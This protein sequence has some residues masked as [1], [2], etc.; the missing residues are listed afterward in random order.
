MDKDIVSG[1]FRDPSGFLFYEEDS[2]YRQINLDYKEDYDILMSSGLYNE[3]VSQMLLI[4][5][6]ESNKNLAKSNEVYK[7]IKPDKIKFISYPYEWSFSQLKD[8]AL[9]TL[10]IIKI[11]LKYGMILKDSSAYNIQFHMGK[12]VLIDTLSFEIYNEGDLWVGYKQFCQHFLAPLALMAYK[13]IRLNQLLRV[14]IDG[15]PLDLASSLL[16]WTSKLNLSL[17]FNI[18]LNA[19]SQKRYGDKEIDVKEYKMKKSNLEALVESLESVVKSMKY[20]GIDTEW[21]DY[22]NFTNYSDDAFE[23]KKGIVSK[24]IDSINSEIVWDLGANTGLFSRLASQKGIYTISF[25]IDPVAVEKNYLQI[26]TNGETNILP[27][28]LDLTNP[29]PGIGWNNKER[30]TLQER[31]LP[32]T[33]LALA[34]IH[35]IA[36]SNNVPLSK[37]AKFFADLCKNLIIEFVPKGDSQVQK[38]L[39]TREDIF[40]DYNQQSF[41]NEFTKYFEIIQSENVKGSHRTLYLMTKLNQ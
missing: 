26:K 39:S 30:E 12:P 22:Y 28:L 18:H 31:G 2:L 33:I 11:S 5:H 14:Y 19:K 17:F 15:I 38:L 25:D 29:S 32:D 20:K 41:E 4:P 7:V 40:K 21:G 8:A 37:I 23:Q 10:K 6:V 3:L 9:C 35:H 24:Y 1:S 13:D 34:L 16:P 27:L 36:I